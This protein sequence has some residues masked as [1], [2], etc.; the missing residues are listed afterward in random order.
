MPP[1]PAPKALS[2]WAAIKAFCR[3]MVEELL[4]MARSKAMDWWTRAQLRVEDAVQR[5]TFGADSEIVVRLRRL[6]HVDRA[7]IGEYRAQALDALPRLELD[8][9]ESMPR[10]WE[11]LTATV[12]GCADGGTIPADAG[13]IRPV[14][15]GRDAVISDLTAI[16]HAELANPANRGFELSSGD[17][18]L[19]ELDGP[20]TGGAIG[21][22]DAHMTAEM[23][24]RLPHPEP[25]ASKGRAS[26]DHATTQAG[27]AATAHAST[28]DP[29]I[30]LANRLRAWAGQR[31]RTLLWRLADRLVAAQNHA[32]DDLESTQT[33]LDELN[34]EISRAG[35]ELATSRRRFRRRSVL[36]ALVVVALAALAVVGF[37]VLSFVAGL[38]LLAVVTIALIPTV[39]AI[40]RLAAERVRLNHRLSNYASRPDALVQRRQHAAS[41]YARLSSLYDQ[42]QDWAPIVASAMH[43]PWGSSKPSSVEPW[44]VDTEVLSFVA[45]TPEFSQARMSRSAVGVAQRMRTAGWLG[46]AY[47]ARR[48]HWLERYNDL[49]AQV[50]Q[51]AQTPEADSSTRQEPL[52]Q[53]D[54][55]ERFASTTVYSARVQF[56]RDFV[57]GAFADEYRS[58]QTARLRDLVHDDN[59]EDLIER[60]HSPIAGLDNDG[61]GRTVAEFLRP[62]VE[63][64]DVPSLSTFLSPWV[65]DDASVKSI[66]GISSAVQST[67]P[68][69]YKRLNV[70]GVEGRLVFAAFRL[71]VTK[72]LLPSETRLVVECRPEPAI[73]VETPDPS[74]DIG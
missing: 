44:T 55:H 51:A 11:L 18:A 71:D 64:I 73:G 15:R 20:A 7:R 48:L 68:A 62:V 46:R 45:G 38:I 41:E 43:R 67:T 10:T 57:S 1:T 8:R 42:F 52:V 3:L 14:F 31:Q 19:L 6:D 49:T 56:R 17:L 58:E 24:S 9:P 22:V 28:P 40:M 12:L 29:R 53:L 59:P 13:K 60:V 72:P 23:L 63:S 30:D 54:A 4:P 27:R 5:R 32:L 25:A 33:E 70:N 39:I 69:A 35:T 2:P 47:S 74:E 21:N 61:C 50:T 16:A 37:A 66:R 26:T 34:A 65:V 36:L